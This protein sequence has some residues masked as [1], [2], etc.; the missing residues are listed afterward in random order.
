MIVQTKNNDTIITI[1]NSVN[2]TYLQDFLDYLTIKS[3][4]SKSKATEKQISD[5]A[6]KA[7]TEWWNKNKS[8]FVK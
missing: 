4:I 5:L 6:E 3:I 8:K 1:P 2:Y 7:Q